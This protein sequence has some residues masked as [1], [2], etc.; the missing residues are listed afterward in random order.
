MFC[1]SAVAVWVY[2]DADL[3][4]TT[5]LMF[6]TTE[7]NTYVQ[8]VGKLLGNQVPGAGRASCAGASGSWGSL[9]TGPYS[10]DQTGSAFLKLVAEVKV[11]NFQ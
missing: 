9:G 11:G 8:E 6:D 2:G 3:T 1:H 7:A 4:G 10:V 5:H